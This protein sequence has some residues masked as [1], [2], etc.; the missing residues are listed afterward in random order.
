MTQSRDKQIDALFDAALDLP[1]SARNE[2]VADSCGTDSALYDEVMQLLAAASDADPTDEERWSAARDRLLADAFGADDGDAEN[3]SGTIV[4]RW[5]LRERIARGGLATVYI[6]ERVDGGFS[7]T[8]A[9]KVLRRGLDTDDLIARFHAERE[10]L[11]ALDHP[12]IADIYDG[13]AL[14][15]GRPY[16]VLEYVDGQPITAYCRDRRLELRDC[17][18]LMIEVLHALHH[19]HQRLVVHRDVKPSNILVTDEGNIAVLDFGIAKLL[20]PEAVPGGSTATRTGVSLLTPGYASPEQRAGGPVTTAS[21][22]Y[23]CGLVLHELL[24]GH[25]PPA[26]HDPGSQV[27]VPSAVTTTRFGK[28][29]LRGDLD[30]IVGK[31]THGDPAQR[32]ASASDMAADLER[33]LSGIPVLARPDSAGYRFRKFARRQPWVIPVTAVTVLALLAYV[34]TI[35]NY[36][37]RLLEQE[38]L[39]VASQ[40]FLVDLFRSPDPFNPADQS[41]GRDITVLQAM[42]LG[43]PRIR[44]E[45]E[46]QPKLQALLLATIGD[47]YSSLDENERSVEIHESAL[48][49]NRQQYG[50]RSP[51]AI[52]S[53][54]ALVPLYRIAG[55]T[56]AASALASQQLDAA[57]ETY[58]PDAPE[59]AIARITA[60]V[61]AYRAGDVDTGRKH[62]ETGIRVLRPHR[63][64][65]ANE[66]ISALIIYATYVDASRRDEAFAAI[67][68]AGRAAGEQYGRSSVQHANV[69]VR[70][71]S[72]LTWMQDYETSERFFLEAL[73]ILEQR[74]GKDHSTTVSALS[75]LAFMYMRKGDVERAETIFHDLL[76]RQRRLFGPD[77]RA[78]ADTSQNLGALYV[79]Q[80]RYEEA[81]AHIDV[82]WRNYRKVL[83]DDNYVIG[84]PLLT[85]A[86]ANIRLGRADAAA[87]AARDALQRFEA[88]M[89]E[90]HL[91]GVAQCLLGAALEHQGK[92]DEGERL[93]AGS[94]Q[95]LGGV[96]I[97]AHYE[98]LCRYPPGGKS[99]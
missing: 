75:N 95:Y 55:K 15:D 49:L 78:V 76:D 12:S 18:A 30:A 93:I 37:R 85:M 50:E 40:Q 4:G 61:D 72:S 70:L 16:L 64:D 42:N 69:R 66:F 27:L 84:Y 44:D 35:T 20:D 81:L 29:R 87:D 51:Q 94:H 48:A 9:V 54:Q 63:D 47:V 71:A 24:T 88:S 62:V 79:K 3:L 11:A 59:F 82:A 17:I 39:A 92:K 77:S 2:F 31:A 56:D 22:V 65:Y 46:N 45:L 36:S 86:Y 7:Q 6:A 26:D 97:G 58:A 21:D 73:P 34:V 53:M 83:N 28:D 91:R 96:N 1:E 14:D 98:E 52:R 19:A 89:P 5:R 99:E 8:A 32:Y 74:I 90:T 80:G 38:Q 57:E 23:Q 25:R 43:L 13:G 60:G 67:D 41:I 68:E 10:I 33:H